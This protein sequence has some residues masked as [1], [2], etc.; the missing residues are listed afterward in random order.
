MK[1]QENHDADL[2]AECLAMGDDLKN[3]IAQIKS[4]D[5]GSNA[6]VLPPQFDYGIVVGFDSKQDCLTYLAHPA[7]V[8]LGE[9]IKPLLAD[10]AQIQFEC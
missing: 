8:A 3:Q 10:A 2:L 1:F 4:Y 7:H 6:G 9:K 5:H